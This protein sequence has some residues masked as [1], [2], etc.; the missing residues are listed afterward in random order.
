MD[1]L[2]GELYGQ[3]LLLRQAMPDLDY[4]ARVYYCV[5]CQHVDG[6]LAPAVDLP[7][8]YA[9]PGCGHPQEALG[10][11]LDLEGERVT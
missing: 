6:A 5:R 11:V 9:C 10:P 8:D 4:C 3:L 1:A 2:L 7:A